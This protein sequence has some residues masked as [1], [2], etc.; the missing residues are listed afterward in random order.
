MSGVPYF[1]G[2]ARAQDFDTASRLF[3]KARENL[4][5]QFAIRYRLDRHSNFFE[6]LGLLTMALNDCKFVW[7]NGKIVPWNAATIH[8]SCHG[9]HY[10]TG[11]FEGMRCYETPS[12]PA[13]FRLGAHMD[14]WFASARIY[15]IA[16]PYSRHDLAQ[17]VLEVL[18]VNQF[19]SCYI[20]PIAFYG[21]HTLA[22]NP[23]GCPTEL[24]ILAWPCA[25]YMG[26]NALVT[27]IDVCISPWRKFSTHAIPARAKA[28][29]QYLNSV[30][31]TQDATTRGFTEALLLDDSGNITE[32]SGENLFLVRGNRLFTNDQASGILPGITRD[33]T[34]RIASDLG[35]DVYVQ[36]LTLNDLRN[37]EEAFLTGTAAEITPIATVDMN[38]IGRGTRGPITAKLQEA[39]L[40]AVS[41]RTSLYHD[42]LTYV[43]LP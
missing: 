33:T 3:T 26:T 15:G 11:V 9:L 20:R 19:G 43:R 16:W 24:A 30:L 35:F 4:T 41:G 29:G 6:Q 12:G 22:V 17:A 32:G 27:G 10:G 28:C 1:I 31:A 13:V 2:G 36:K 5:R 21:S 39:Y 34:M 38:V 37:A 8:I 7:K 23:K 18:R 42:W 40:K 14:R 25:T